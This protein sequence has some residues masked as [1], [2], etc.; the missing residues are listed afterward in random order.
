MIND[1][2]IRDI[3]KDLKFFRIELLQKY[4]SDESLELTKIDSAINKMIE[5][6]QGICSD[7]CSIV[8]KESLKEHDMT[9]DNV[10]IE[11]CGQ[12]YKLKVTYEP[13]SKND[14]SI[15]KLDIVSTELV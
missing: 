3:I 1:N 4:S 5:L 14:M 13:I 12:L 10:I 11:S 6:R 2:S 9:G 7:Y 8:I 15:K